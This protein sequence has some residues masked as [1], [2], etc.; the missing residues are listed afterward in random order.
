M[1][2][3]IM[4]DVSQSQST[5]HQSIIRFRHTWDACMSKGRGDHSIST[6]RSSISQPRCNHKPT[7]KRRSL[8]A[9]NQHWEQEN[10]LDS[11]RASFPLLH[12]RISSPAGAG[13]VRHFPARDL[14]RVNYSTWPSHPY[15][16]EREQLA[17]KKRSFPAPRKIP[18]AI[19]RFPCKSEID[20]SGTLPT[21]LPPP[22]RSL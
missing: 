16:T 6:N 20:R 13:I 21:I 10:V 1:R 18:I 4:Q 12:L 5:S 14:S 8:S 22:W 7:C 9:E 17:V 3:C 15:R 2:P 11:T 19:Y